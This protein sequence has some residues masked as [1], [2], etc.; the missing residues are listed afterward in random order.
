LGIL[1]AAVI[2]LHNTLDLVRAQQFGAGAWIWNLLHQVGA[3]QF[4]GKLMIVG[5]PLVPWVA[6]MAAGFCAGELFLM[7]ADRRRRNLLRI[8]LAATI[9]FVVIRAVNLYG[10]PQP[11]SARRC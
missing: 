4:A 9:A 3:F 11:R 6:V 5:Y 8:G 2:L 7:D 1:S 10:D